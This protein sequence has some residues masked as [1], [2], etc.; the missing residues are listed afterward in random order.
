[1]PAKTD[2]NLGFNKN[3]T[4]HVALLIA[5]SLRGR[6]TVEDL[7]SISDTKFTNSK[8]TSQSLCL[9]VKKGLLEKNH[10]GWA[11]TPAG[12]AHLYRTAPQN[13]LADLGDLS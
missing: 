13:K 12:I 8:L 2:K 7:K 4:T 5:K 9:L 3:G 6:F 1:M 11:I 10:K